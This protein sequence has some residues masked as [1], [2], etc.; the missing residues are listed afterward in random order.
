MSLTLEQKNTLRSYLRTKILLT[1][2]QIE[3]VAPLFEQALPYEDLIKFAIYAGAYIRIY[4]SEL[5]PG[6]MSSFFV[7][8]MLKNFSTS[9]LRRFGVR[10]RLTLYQIMERAVKNELQRRKSAEQLFSLT[11]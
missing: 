7:E 1:D 3:R 9:R 2:V 8:S 4:C 11:D 6:E 5:S 10:K